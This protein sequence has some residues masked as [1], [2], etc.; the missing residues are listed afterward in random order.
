MPVQIEFINLIARID[1]IQQK[2][3]GGF[4]ACLSDHQDELG[5]VAWHDD[6]L[7]RTG[8]MSPIDMESIVEFWESKGLTGAKSC[9]GQMHWIDFCV[10]DSI[11]GPTYICPWIE[12]T[13]YRS[14][15][16]FGSQDIRFVGR[17][18]NFR[19]LLELK[20]NGPK[21]NIDKAWE[22]MNNTI[23]RLAPYSRPLNSVELGWAQDSEVPNPSRILV[24]EVE[25][26]P[27]P[28]DLDLAYSA[29]KIRFLGPATVGITLN[30]LIVVL[31]GYYSEGLMR[32]EL[33][34][35]QQ[36]QTASSPLSFLREYIQQVYADGYD[37]C[38]LEKD[39]RAFGA[40]R[41]FQN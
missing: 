6:H 22:F 29:K 32:H 7:F 28:K 8:A 2:Y 23:F 35:C 1:R 19:D 10:V 14:V 30:H 11:F 24:C 16:L 41:Q 3:P 4:D 38:S 26:M 40:I 33:R 17:A 39:A 9:D 13:G 21:L 36:W 15:K 18:S 31:K 34:H 27:F 20:H 37:S 12:L 25:Q 5:I